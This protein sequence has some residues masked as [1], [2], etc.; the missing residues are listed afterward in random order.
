MSTPSV[1]IGI[2]VA[3]AELVAASPTADICRVPNASGGFRS[4]IAHLSSLSI[5]AVVMESTGCYGREAAA[6]L[7][8]AG[9]AVAIVQAGRVRHFAA[10][11]GI[12][13]KT[14]PIDARVI[15][16]FAEATKPRCTPPSS[17]A[18]VK[19]RALV[20]RREQVIE[21]R[22]QEGNRLESVADPVIAKELKRSIARLVA[23]E[24]AYTKQIGACMDAHPEFRRISERL[25]AESGVGLQTAATLLAYFPELG[26]INRQQAAALA[27]LAPYDHASGT[28]DGKRTICGGRRR[29]RR[30]LYL[31]AVSAARWSFWVKTFY[32]NL[33]ARGKCA[34]VALIACARKLLVRL[35]SLA[36]MALSDS[37][38]TREPLT[39]P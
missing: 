34:K 23:A 24:A 38:N 15:A 7:T 37:E 12:R 35:N 10:S 16:R 33:R 26:R 39:A 19:L 1:Y 20:D 9:Y 29:I 31:A 18:I 28:H 13:A 21:M 27:G 32:A 25:Q 5:V 22:K 6:A 8:A 30:A 2:D 36:A 4:L 17:A 3:K 14:D 11:L